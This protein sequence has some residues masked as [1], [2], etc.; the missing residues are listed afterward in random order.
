MISDPCPSCSGT[1]R[2]HEEKKLSVKVPAGVD[3]GTRLRVAGEGE[4]GWN[5]GPPGDLYVFISVEEDD[6]FVRRDY[7]IHVELP[8]T[9]T[10]VA[11]GTEIMVKT[12]HGEEKL[13]VPAATQPDRVFRFKGKGVPFVDGSGRGDHFVHVKLHVPGNLSARQR[14]LL[15][16]LATLEG[17]AP[18]ERGVFDKMKGFFHG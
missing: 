9:Y 2:V 14:E 8:L 6:H 15:E 11:L 10:Q 17:E 1:G 5:G 18:G 4:A 12:I 16:E 7:D 13:K 3:D